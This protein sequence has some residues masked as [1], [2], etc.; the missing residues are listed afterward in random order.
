[1]MLLLCWFGKSLYGILHKTYESFSA[2]PNNTSF[3]Q[4][5][6]KSAVTIQCS[7]RFTKRVGNDIQSERPEKD[8]R[9]PKKE[10]WI[11]NRDLWRKAR[12][13]KRAVKLVEERFTIKQAYQ[14]RIQLLL[15]FCR[16]WLRIIDRLISRFRIL[17]TGIMLS[18]GMRWHTFFFVRKRGIHCT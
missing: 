15:F 16:D 3:S 6:E 7:S 2:C 9:L 12:W 11:M 13:K 4:H 5:N 1:M 8:I 14:T 10:I 17:R 18:S